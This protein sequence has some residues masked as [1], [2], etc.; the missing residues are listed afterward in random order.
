MKIIHASIEHLSALHQISSQT[1]RQHFSE[2]W[3]EQGIQQFIQ[4]QYSLENIQKSLQHPDH[5]WLLL[6][7][8]QQKILGYA[9]L[10]LNTFQPNLGIHATELE[11]IYVLEQ[12]LGQNIAAKLMQS[13]LEFAQNNAQQFIYLEVLKNNLRAQKFYQKFGFEEK[14][15]I[16]FSTDLYEIG[17]LIMLKEL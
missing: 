3:T 15:E 2:I 4:Q 1:Y 6:Q 16:P 11:K 13:V 8:D 5:I 14:L 9:K 10:I 17:M 12:A 7:D